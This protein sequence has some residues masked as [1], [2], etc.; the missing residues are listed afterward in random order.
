MRISISTLLMLS[1]VMCA[2]AHT[3]GEAVEYAVDN[4][5]FK[6]Y[7]AYNDDILGKRPGVC[8][9]FTNGGD[10]TTMCVIGHGCWLS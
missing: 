9:L 4:M 7:L 5:V 6:G 3:H 2:S 10:T 1:I 8:W